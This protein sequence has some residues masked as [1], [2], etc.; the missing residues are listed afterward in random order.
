MR[1]SLAALA[2]KPFTQRYDLGLEEG[3]SYAYALVSPI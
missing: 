2:P 3:I 1:L